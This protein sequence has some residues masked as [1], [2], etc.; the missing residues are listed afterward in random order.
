MNYTEDL[1]MASDEITG[2]V[3]IWDARTAA[4]LQRWRGKLNY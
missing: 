2:E 3:V 1:V 4:P